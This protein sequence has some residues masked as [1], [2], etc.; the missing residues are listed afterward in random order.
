[1]RPIPLGDAHNE[2]TWHLREMLREPAF[3]AVALVFGVMHCIFSVVMLHL[4]GAL[5]HQFVDG[6][7]LLQRMW[8]G[9][10]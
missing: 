6:D 8:S 2:K 3:W 1:M 7:S 5:K 10:R 9:R 4:A